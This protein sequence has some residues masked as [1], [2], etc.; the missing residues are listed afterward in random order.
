MTPY[1]AQIGLF[2]FNF[3]PKGWSL[4]QAQILSISQN[5]A[6][7]SLLGTTYGGN[8]VSTFALPDLRGRT[9]V[10]WGQGNGLSSYSIG[11]QAGTQNVTLL[12]NNLPLHNHPFSASNTAATTA[13]P[14]GASPSI[15][16][17]NLSCMLYSANA[18]D[19]VMAVSSV[20]NAGSNVPISILQPY[21][22]LNYS[23]A[24]NGIFPSRN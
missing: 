5:A 9:G 15:G 10:H 4:C 1:I 17:A 23:I 2:G 8:G 6:L 20:A 16:Q 18:S 14:S 22:C 13:S 19:V 11:Q 7:F 21:L 12:A 24:L 3:P